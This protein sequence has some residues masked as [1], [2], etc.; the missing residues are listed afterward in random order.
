M[1]AKVVVNVPSS[2]TDQFFD[3]SLPQEFSEFAKIGARVKVPFG[4]GNREI[5]GYILD[6]N[7]TSLYFGTLKNIIEVVDYEPVLSEKQLQIANFIKEDT[8]S[9]LVRILNLMI[10]DAL[11]LKTKKYLTIIDYQA[12]D[13][14]LV[15]LFNQDK[16]IEYT[17]KCRPYD[18]IIAKEIKK[19]NIVVSYDAL[20]ITKDKLVDKYVLN[21]NFTYQNYANLKNLKQ[22]EFLERLHSEIA[23]TANELCDKYEISPNWLITLSKKGFLSKIKVKESRIKTRDI[24]IEKRI[25]RTN[26]PIVNQLIEKLDVYIKPLLYIPRNKTQELEMLL[27]VIN[28]NLK[29]QK[30]TIIFVP[31][32]LSSY[33]IENQLRKH[34]GLK[35]GMINS[36]MTSGEIL[37]FY[38]EIK[39]NTY[40]VIVTTAKGALFD[41]QNVG[42]Y[43]LL[44]SESDNYYNDQSPRY[45]LHKVIEQIAK[46]NSSQV[47]RVSL[48]PDVLEYTYALKGYLD[49]IEDFNKEHLFKS[50][51]VDL[52]K[53]LQMGNNKSVSSDLLKALKLT[54]YN[55]QKSLLI[56]N[57]KSYSSYVLCRSCGDIIKCP[58]CLVSLQYNKKNEKL[59]CPRCGY[60][61]PFQNECPTC[62]SHELKLGG[63]GIEQLVEDL[64]T[65]LPE[66]K[67][68]SL[69]DNTFEHF[70]EIE[71]DFEDGDIDIL[72]TTELYSKSLIGKNIGLVAFINIDNTSKMA[73][74]D[75]NFRAYKALCQVSE[76]LNDNPESLLIV[77]TY[78]PND[79]YLKDFLGGDYHQFIKNEIAQRKILRNEP[80]YFVNRILVKGKYEDIFK[81]TQDIKQMLQTSFGNNVFVLGPSYNY[82]YGAAQIII[83]HKNNN[84]SEFYQQIYQ[85]YQSTTTMIIIDKYPKYI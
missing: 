9:P 40:P 80:F 64:Q 27:Q 44:D 65:I 58:R 37:D 29:K 45:D 18:N 10:P 33:Q 6:I 1:I 84:I 32:I 83:K 16:M 63:I 69:V 13:A 31:E 2:N 53:E 34:T 71:T 38:N 26:D 15:E 8:A 24:P 76:K 79:Q 12:V 3:Y 35:I 60:N 30:N 72:V 17:E 59:I 28:Y 23:M 54:K 68:N 74:Y 62:K 5:M 21:P 36:R 50:K 48:V 81:V 11:K 66:F 67:T 52:K 55:N 49:I 51:I 22:R 85:K 19:Q 77:Q 70:C 42:T 56:V 82:Q 4:D 41:Y 43:L 46:L 75:A 25:R 39:N 78:N 61:M 20:E 14:R 7:E 73:D 57:N 47:V